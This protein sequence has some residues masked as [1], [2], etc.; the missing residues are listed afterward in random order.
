MK[1]ALLTAVALACVAFGASAKVYNS[2]SFAPQTDG[3]VQLL[4]FGRTSETFDF[5]AAPGGLTNFFDTW[6]I[7][8]AGVAPGEY[9][10]TDMVIDS[11]GPLRFSSITFNSIDAEGVRHTILFD[12]STPRH[13]VG[14][15][16]FTVL[17]S[18]PIAS[19]V[20]IDVVGQQ[21]GVPTAGYGGTTVATP[22]P[23]PASYGMMALG[24]VGIGA[25][26]RR[27]RA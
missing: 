9:S 22:V 6:N 2:A 3:S 11:T 1:K 25:F 10:F 19:C 15:G 16:T 20:W 18:C 8:T 4:G 24:L 13:A 12:L 7:G 27:R 26:A 17:E 5:L 21:R 23:E 14:S